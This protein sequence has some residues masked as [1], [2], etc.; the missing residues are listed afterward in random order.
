MRSEECTERKRAH[1]AAIDERGGADAGGL[2][3]GKVFAPRQRGGTQHVPLRGPA[4]SSHW[5]LWSPSP[6]EERDIVKTDKAW[7]LE[8]L[9]DALRFN[10]D[11]NDNSIDIPHYHVFIERPVCDTDE[12]ERG[13]ANP[14]SWLK[15]RDD[16]F[17]RRVR[18]RR[19]RRGDATRRTRTRPRPQGCGF[20]RVE[21]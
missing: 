20:D 13:R 16:G 3:R 6:M 12:D 14:V 5:T 8:H 19:R 15:I 2:H 9:P 4:S 1:V 11:L 18:G 17:G 10:Y 7:L 21:P